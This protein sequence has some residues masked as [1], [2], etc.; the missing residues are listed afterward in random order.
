MTYM[1]TNGSRMLALQPAAFF[2]TE[3][4]TVIPSHSSVQ[5][6]TSYDVTTSRYKTAPVGED[7][8]A[9]YAAAACVSLAQRSEVSIPGDLTARE[10]YRMRN[11]CLF[12]AVTLAWSEFL[13]LCL[14][15]GCTH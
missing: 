3:I 5:D 4:H 6:G 2:H 8:K 9:I 7:T 10:N 1:A 12:L 15:A 14:H 11:L 13:E